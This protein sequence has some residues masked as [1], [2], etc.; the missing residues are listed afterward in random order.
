VGPGCSACRYRFLPLPSAFRDG[1]RH[2]VHPIVRM[3]PVIPLL[4]ALLLAFAQPASTPPQ[5]GGRYVP[6]PADAVEGLPYDP[7]T[8]L[9]ALGRR[10]TFYLSKPPAL[11][12][13][14][15][16][17]VCVQGL[18]S[19]S[20]FLE[21]ETPDGT[22]IASGGPEAAMLKLTRDRARVLVVEKPGVQ[23]L[24]QPRRPGSAEEGSEEF[25]R[26]HSL[27][28]W[29]EAINAAVR[30]ACTLPGVDPARVLAVGHS[31][32]GQVVCHL[33]AANDRITHVATLAGSGP[34][35]LFDLNELARAGAF[36][37]PGETADQ[38]VA[39]VL[40]GWRRVLADPDS[41]DRLWM[42]HPHLRWSSFLRTSPVEALHRSAA[43]VFIAQGTADTASLPASADVL[44][45]ELLARGRDVTYERVEGGDHGFRTPQ[46]PDGWLRVHA[47]VARWFL[48]D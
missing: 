13:T 26:E 10:I 14:L 25:R 5:P 23:F 43:R 28:R 48:G 27:E 31:E 21:V 41:H 32:G 36:G 38:R 34:T 6:V 2:R 17:I 8:T 30:A 9:D 15:P 39:R 16:L 11:D 3:N 42:G 4:T 22:R 7:Y 37:S 12:A 19:Q 33:A 47:A 20:V 46:D 18:G 29:T 44:Y 35:Q 45:A 24:M 1:S 40:E